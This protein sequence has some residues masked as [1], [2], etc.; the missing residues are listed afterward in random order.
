M[1]Q[2]DLTPR[3]RRLNTVLQLG[4]TAFWLMPIS[5]GIRS[6]LS[7]DLVLGVMLIVIFVTM[8]TLSFRR[9]RADWDFIERGPHAGEVT[10]AA[11]DYIVV[12]FIGIP[13]LLVAFLVIRLVFH[14][15]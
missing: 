6:L 9:A 12:A 10:P 15:D 3:Q 11:F 2:P 8:F 5:I 4:L 1:K 13:I 14:I 7:G